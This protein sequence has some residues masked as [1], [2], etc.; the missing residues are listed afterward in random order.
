[1]VLQSSRVDPR[2]FPRRS[3]PRMQCM[4]F[5]FCLMFFLDRFTLMCY[6]VLSANYATHTQYPYCPTWAIDWEYRRRGILEELRHYAPSLICLQEIDTDQFEGVF[7]PELAR[8]GYEGAFLAKSRSRTMDPSASRKVD[9][10]A[11]FWLTEKFTKVAE[12][13]HE[14]MLSCGSVSDRPSDLLLNRVM[15][16]DNV[17]IDVV[18]E[19]TGPTGRFPYHCS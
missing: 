5:P 12:F 10:C 4:K 3:I 18:L 7:V 1:M 11:I 19:T 8:S 17:A 13:H 6:N 2:P 16:R 9:G 15:T 14:F